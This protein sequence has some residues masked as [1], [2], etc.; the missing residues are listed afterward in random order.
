MNTPV[1][2]ERIAEAS[3]RP[4][5][6]ITGVVYLLFFLTVISAEFFVK[7]LVVDGDAAAT[8]NNIL[9]HESLFRVGFAINLIATALYIAVTA[10][11]YDLFKPVNRSLSLLAAFFSLVG[12]AIQAFSYVFYL[13]PFVLLGGSQYLSV[14]KVEQLQALALMLLKLRS[15]AEQ[16]DLVFFGFYD[17][18]IGCLILRS[19]FLPRILGGLMALAGLAWLIFLLPPLANYLSYYILPL[20]FLAELLLMLW[21]LVKGVNVQRWME[22]AGAAGE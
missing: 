4:R 7:G 17:L 11:F 10:L 3:P 18:L 8:A 20:G 12:C 19:T 9:A 22:Q 15:Q 21:L 13:A 14:F 16:I 2:M 6:R 5:A 1:M